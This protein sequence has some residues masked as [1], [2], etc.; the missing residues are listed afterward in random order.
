MGRSEAHPRRT[1]RLPEAVRGLVQ[2]VKAYERTIIRAAEC[3]SGALLQL[4]MLEC[5]IIGEWELAG[6]LRMALVAADP[7]HL[8]YL[9]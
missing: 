1:G 6:K 8:G 5:P 2:S 7:E 3:G 9:K 4:A